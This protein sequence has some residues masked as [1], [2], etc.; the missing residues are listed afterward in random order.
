MGDRSP[1]PDDG[2][3]LKPHSGSRRALDAA[4]SPPGTLGGYL[5]PARGLRRSAGRVGP[6]GFGGQPGGGSA[7]DQRRRRNP[8]RRPAP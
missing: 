3:G 4:R 6:L 5:E 7:R 2:A 8:R 1:T